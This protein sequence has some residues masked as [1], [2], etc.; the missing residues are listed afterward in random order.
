MLEDEKAPFTEHLE[1]LRKRLVYSFIAVAVGF[2]LTYAFKELLFEILIHPLVTVM[3]PGDHLVFTGIAE[4]FFTYLKVA[5]LAGLMLAAPVIFYQFWM[6]VAPGLYQHERR[7]LL[8][9]VIIS[10]FFF[11]G[12]A[13]FGYFVVF[14]IGFKFF[15]GYSTETIKPMLSMKE[16][17]RFSSLFL[18]AFGVVFEPPILLTFL[19]RLGIVS[20]DFLKKNRKYAILLI[21]IVAAVLTPTPDVVS[22]GLMAIPLMILYEVGIVGAKIFGKKKS[23][24]TVEEP[25]A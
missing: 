25:S 7:L 16:Y 24:E 10:S 6:F 2:A 11:I 22:Q 4:A 8:P 9:V 17:L 1:E 23:E 19:A 3:A 13:L 12:G 15:L 18:L 21:F 20:V 5:F 14:P